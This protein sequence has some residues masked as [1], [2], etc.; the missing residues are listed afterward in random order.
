MQPNVT[1]YIHVISGILSLSISTLSLI[2]M[3]KRQEKKRF[4]LTLKWWVMPELYQTATA[5][6]FGIFSL[7]DVT[8]A[9][10]E[11]I[12]VCVAAFG[13]EISRQL[14]CKSRSLNCVQHVGSL[15]LTAH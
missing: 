8:F 4:H 5:N 12:G 3:V 10:F 6:R 15:A 1:F 2:F 11:N 13:T 14:Q 7:H 9:V